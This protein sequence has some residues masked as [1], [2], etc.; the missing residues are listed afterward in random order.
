METDETLETEAWNSGGM[1][2]SHVETIE[3]IMTDIVNSMDK[4]ES[5]LH[6]VEFRDEYAQFQKIQREIDTLMKGLGL[7]CEEA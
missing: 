7:V 2:I 3:D 6:G 4:L 5:K 1:E